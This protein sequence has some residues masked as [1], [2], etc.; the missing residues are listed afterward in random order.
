MAEKLEMKDMIIQINKDFN[1]LKEAIDTK[2]N[3]AQTKEEIEKIQDAIDKMETKMQ[4]QTAKTEN[5]NGFDLSSGEMKDFD[6]YLR[7]GAISAELERKTLSTEVNTDGGYLVAYEMADTIRDRL[8]ERSPIRQI[9]TVEVIS[10]AAAWIEPVEGET[11]FEA[12]W[13]GERAARPVTDTGTIR[14]IKIPL[15]ELYAQPAVNR[16]MLTDT[17]FNLE[18]YVARK[19]EIRFDRVEGDAFVNG[20]GVNKPMGFLFNT[21]TIS[22]T[23]DETSQGL[24]VVLGALNFDNIIGLMYSL[25]E[26]YMPNARYL[27]HRLTIRNIRQLK[28]NDGQYLWQP[29]MIVGKPNTILGSEYTIATHMPTPATGAFSLAYGDFREGYKIVESTDMFT[30]RDEYTNK[31]NI[32]YYTTKRV[33]GNIVMDKAIKLLRQS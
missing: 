20:D 26:P 3:D 15:Q 5:K 31:P 8:R 9:A 2:A 25:E 24:E 6:D 14:E 16:R 7:K 30:L 13:V 12:G 28:D 4:R 27:A 18:E 1:S 11:E 29:S 19:L 10:G 22:Q 32:L 21:N 23:G 33:G 17:K